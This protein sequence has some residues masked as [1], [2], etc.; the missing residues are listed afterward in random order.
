MTRATGTKGLCLLRIYLYTL[1]TIQ[2]RAGV[3]NLWPAGQMWPF[4]NSEEQKKVTKK[5]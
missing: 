3:A 1:Y 5:I 4:L 2:Y